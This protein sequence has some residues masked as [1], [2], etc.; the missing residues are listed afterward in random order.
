MQL[1]RDKGTLHISA[2]LPARLFSQVQLSLTAEKI[3]C[4]QAYGEKLR[5]GRGL[6]YNIGFRTNFEED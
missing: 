4:A 5:W 3:K 1:S 2:D 6:I